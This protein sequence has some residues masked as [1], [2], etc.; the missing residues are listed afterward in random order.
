MQ[1]RGFNSFASNMIKLWVKET[2]WS[3]L[4]A[5][6]RALIFLYFDLKIWFRARNVTGIFEKRAPAQSF[7]KRLI[8]A[9]IPDSKISGRNSRILEIYLF[10]QSLSKC[11]LKRY[12]NPDVS[13]VLPLPQWFWF[14][15]GI[16]RSEIGDGSEK[17]QWKPNFA[18]FQM[19][20]IVILYNSLSLGN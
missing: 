7:Q 12:E 18:S 10:L 15:L 2:K 4:L 14:V 9:D 17:R 16:C 6:T 5:R 11:A 20:W 13:R 1:D 19:F 8:V 3:S